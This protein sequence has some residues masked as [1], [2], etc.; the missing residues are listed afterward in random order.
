MKNYASRNLGGT[1]RCSLLR[2]R[3][4]NL[5]T[6]KKHENVYEKAALIK[7]L[8]KDGVVRGYDENNIENALEEKFKEFHNL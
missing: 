8:I 4:L 5:E 7:S 2:S 1:S 6:G 3:N